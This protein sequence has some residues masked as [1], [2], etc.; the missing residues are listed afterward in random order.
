MAGGL[1]RQHPEQHRERE[2][3]RPNR[4]RASSNIASTCSIEYNGWVMIRCAPASTLRSSRS[5]SVAASAA[6]GSS[7]QAIVNEAAL[8]DRRPGRILA[9]VEAREDP[10]EPDR[11]DVPDAGPGRVVADPRRVAGQGE[12]VADAE[13]VRA[14]QLR[15]EGHQVP[16]ARREVDDALEIQVVL[17]A[18]RHG[19]APIRTRA[20]AESLMLTVSTPGRLEQAGGLDRPLDADGPRRVDLDRDDEPAVGQGA[21]ARPRGRRRLVGRRRRSRSGPSC[22]RSGTVAA[23]AARPEHSRHARASIAAPHRRDV[24]GRRAAAAADDRRAGVEHVADHPAEV[25]GPGRVHELALDALRQAGVGEDRPCPRR[26]IATSA[27]RQPIGPAP[28]FTPSTSASTRDRERARRPPRAS[29]PSASTTSSPNVIRRHDRQ[30]GRRGSRLLDGDREV[31]DESRTSR[32]RRRRRRPRAG[33]RW[34]RGTPPGRRHRRGGR[35]SRFGAPERPDRSGDQHVAAG[36]VARLAGDLRAAAGQLA[37]LV[38]QAVR[39]EPDAV[40]AERGGLDDVGAGGQVLAVD[41]ADQLGSA[42]DQLVE[43]RLAAGCRG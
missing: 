34:A 3:A 24:L 4:R 32:T 25:V 43:A 1:E 2:P 40:R 6:V 27:S 31:V 26:P 8:T 21:E 14:E 37:G 18:E 17:D 19:Q 38:G 41:R 9:P 39:G 15:L 35:S 33:P 7:A 10:D 5:H 20:I 29:V 30:V 13:R 28:Q 11:V 16:V 22:S 36:D 23:R 12:D 42:R